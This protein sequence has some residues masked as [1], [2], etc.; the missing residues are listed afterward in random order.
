MVNIL[1]IN[2]QVV[3]VNTYYIIFTTDGHDDWPT[4]EAANPIELF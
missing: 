3:N 4:S 1:T 2:L